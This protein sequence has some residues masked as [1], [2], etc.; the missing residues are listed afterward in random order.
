MSKRL[1]DLLAE[2]GD[3]AEA[4]EADQTDRPIPPHVK[5]TRGNPRSKVLQVRLNPEELE[6][7]ERIARRRELPVSTIAREQLLRLIAEDHLGEPRTRWRNCVTGLPGLPT[8][9]SRWPTRSL[10]HLR[11]YRQTKVCAQSSSRMYSVTGY[12]HVGHLKCRKRH[13]FPS[14]GLYQHFC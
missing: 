10:A 14:P 2:I 11:V 13:P 5:I 9:S 1:D 8:P 3:E 7:L 12:R 4:A 6:S